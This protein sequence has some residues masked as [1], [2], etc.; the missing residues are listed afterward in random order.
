MR[1]Q[2]G[3]VEDLVHGQRRRIAASDEADELPHGDLL[4]QSGSLLHGPDAAPDPATGRLVED[5]DLAV[6]GANQPEQQFECRRLART[7][8]S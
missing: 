5:G 2:T 1:S 8:G 4:G 6:R 7:V 3:P